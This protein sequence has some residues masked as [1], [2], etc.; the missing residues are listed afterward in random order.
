MIDFLRTSHMKK[1]KT[2]MGRQHLGIRFASHVKMHG[3]QLLSFPILLLY[4]PTYLSIHHLR[5]WV[6]LKRY[7]VGPSHLWVIVQLNQ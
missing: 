4:L 7:G 6:S 3:A 5:L 1:K 2:R